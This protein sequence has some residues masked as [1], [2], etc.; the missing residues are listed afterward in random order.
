[1]GFTFSKLEKVQLFSY[2]CL[3]SLD[4]VLLA[5]KKW[6]LVLAHLVEPQQKPSMHYTIAWCFTAVVFGH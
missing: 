2:V 3:L 6:I 5:L 1:L 4:A